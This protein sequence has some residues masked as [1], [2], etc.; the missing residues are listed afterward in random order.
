MKT[1]KDGEVVFQVEFYSDRY[2]K[3]RSITDVAFHPTR[4]ELLLASYSEAEAGNTES[5][6]LVLL[7]S[8]QNT[9]ERPEFVFTCQSQVCSAAF[10]PF[11]SRIVIGG[12]YCGQIII[13]DV[14]SKT[15]SP[16]LQSP[17]SNAGHTH[18]VYSLAV[19]GT[20]HAHNLVSVSTDGRMCAWR[21][22]DLRQPVEVDH[23]Y[24]FICKSFTNPGIR[25]L[26]IF[27]LCLSFMSDVAFA[28]PC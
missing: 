10:S 8:L 23:F 18:P 20:Q 4:P 11:D 28:S 1:S 22:D 17:L 9:L 5:N 15:S 27:F 24:L 26:F 19:V 3:H 7:W 25:W 2:C 13:W 16:V 12:T 21:L 14:R 6:G